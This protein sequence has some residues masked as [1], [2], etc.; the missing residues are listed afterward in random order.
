VLIQ[1][2]NST[3]PQFSLMKVRHEPTDNPIRTLLMGNVAKFRIRTDKA[4]HCIQLRSA[5]LVQDVGAPFSRMWNF[6]IRHP[7]PLQ[8]LPCLPA[9]LYCYH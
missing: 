5:V 7:H 6:L 8:I 1:T 9:F 3:S 2:S 4:A